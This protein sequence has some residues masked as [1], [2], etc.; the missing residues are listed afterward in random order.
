MPPTKRAPFSKTVPLGH[1]FPKKVEN[2]AVLEKGH[3]FRCKKR[4]KMVPF[5]SK[6]HRFGHHFSTVYFSQWSL[7]IKRARRRRVFQCSGL[8]SHMI[9]VILCQSI[10]RNRVDIDWYLHFHLTSDRLFYCFLRFSLIRLSMLLN[11]SH[12]GSWLKAF[13][14]RKL[15]ILYECILPDLS[16]WNDGMDLSFLIGEPW[17]ESK[18]SMIH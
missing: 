5:F 13:L 10:F 1:H 4:S 9:S 17:K 11:K 14:L 2:G 18:M 3:C 12:H 8:H 7:L 6:G 16:G 15:M